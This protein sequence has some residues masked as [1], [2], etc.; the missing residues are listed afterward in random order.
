MKST[1]IFVRTKSKLYPIYFG[2]NIINTVGPLIIKNL[3]KVKKICVIVDKNLPSN[4]L[5]KLNSSLKK[6]N[7]TIYKLSVSERI[8]NFQLAYKLSENIIV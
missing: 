5:K 1:K 4:I 2:E 7:T 6:Y 3:P 8:K